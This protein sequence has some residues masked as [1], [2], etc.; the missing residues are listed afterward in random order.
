[1]IKNR[2]AQEAIFWDKGFII[3]DD[4]ADVKWIWGIYLLLY[5]WSY[6]DLLDY[7]SI[8]AS[9]WTKR[10]SIL[11]ASYRFDDRHLQRC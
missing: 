3:K 7:Y 8:G 11:S 10:P 2:T 6:Y 1:M 9:A 4:K 5:T